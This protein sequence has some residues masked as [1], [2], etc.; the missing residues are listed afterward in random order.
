V[1]RRSG[2]T[3]GGS[4]RRPEQVGEVIRQVI[5]EALTRE[6]RDPRIGLVTLTRVETS[7]DLSHARIF[8]AFHRD[9]SE[10]DLEPALVGLRSAAGFLRGKVARALSTRITPELHF[11]LDRGAEHAARI[12]AL[13]EGLKQ[14]PES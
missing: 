2:K 11:D 8:V 6:V 14:E 10:T 9:S 4:R 3:G 1:A 7:P 13:L 5:A 12:N